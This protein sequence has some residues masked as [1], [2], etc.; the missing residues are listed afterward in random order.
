M[1]RLGFLGFFSFECSSRT[2]D[3]DGELIRACCCYDGL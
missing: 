1:F 3:T 2:W